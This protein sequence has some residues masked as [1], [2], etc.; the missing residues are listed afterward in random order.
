[1]LCVAGRSLLFVVC[2]LC[3]VCCGVAL[4]RAV[5]VGCCSL[6][7][8]SLT[9]LLLFARCVFVVAGCL[10]YDASRASC[11]WRLSSLLVVCCVCCRMSCVPWFVCVVCC[12][13]VVC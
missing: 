6:L 9:L 13:L 8:V 10:L 3:D 7:V 1:M 12:V 2:S 4:L 5:F 11:A